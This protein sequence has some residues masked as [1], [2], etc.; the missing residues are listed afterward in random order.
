MQNLLNDARQHRRLITSGPL[1]GTNFGLGG[2]S[3]SQ[4][5]YG[6]YGLAPTSGGDMAG[7][8]RVRVSSRR[9]LIR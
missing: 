2:N 4:F 9:A 3:I 7:G 5:Q 6:Q 8:T 1:K